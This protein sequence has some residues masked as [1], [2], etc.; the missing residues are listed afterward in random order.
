[1][2]LETEK[3]NEELAS[4]HAVI[5]VRLDRIGDWK[6]HPKEAVLRGN[7]KGE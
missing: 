4:N 2:V 7:V 1:M 3:E 5:N 6:H